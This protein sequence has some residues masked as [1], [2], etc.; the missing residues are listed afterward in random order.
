MTARIERERER[1][2]QATMRQGETRLPPYESSSE[3]ERGERNVGGQFGCASGS[4][5]SFAPNVS[6]SAQKNY[7]QALV[8]LYRTPL[9]EHH[10]FLMVS[11]ATRQ[12][13][14]HFFGLATKYCPW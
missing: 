7:R 10:D 11:A 6:G 13:T 3:D 2:A 5:S 1:E 12:L 4:S 9:Y 8:A 14:L